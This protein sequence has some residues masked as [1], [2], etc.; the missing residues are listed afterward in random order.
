MTVEVEKYIEE[1]IGKLDFTPL[2][3]F[4]NGH[5]RIQM[6]FSE[7]VYRV[8]MDGLEAFNKETITTFIFDTLF[9]EI[10]IVRPIFV[11]IMVF[12]LLFSIVHRLLITKN[13]YISDISFLFV[14]ATLMVMLMQSLYFV[15]QI[16]LDGMESLLAFLNALIPTYAAT[17]G[18]FRKCSKWSYIV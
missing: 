15:R 3:E 17:N 6:T 11:K 12:S 5:M 7:L 8:S 2:N 14:Y 16:A 9:Y 4:L 1:I 10:S 13:K 18:I